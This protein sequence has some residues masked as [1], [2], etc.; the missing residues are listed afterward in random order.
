MSHVTITSN[1]R[2]MVALVAI[3]SLLAGCRQPDGPMPMPTP[4][5][6][7]K[8]GDIARDLQNV[9]AKSDG[10]LN[11]L[12]DD[13]L[14]LSSKPPS[15][16]LVR[17]LAA[18]LDQA[19]AGSSPTAEVTQRL[20]ETLFIVLTARELSERQVTRLQTDVTERVRQ[21]NG[22]VQRSQVVA[23]VTE[24]IQKDITMNPRR[25]FQVF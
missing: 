1:A 25:W 20:A 21:V 3:C 15:L 12:T 16:Q 2:L 9:A 18:A 5:Q 10:A 19:L 22:D 8:T 11:E 4:E 7:N 13:L 6:S 23:A 14:N 24:K 17:E